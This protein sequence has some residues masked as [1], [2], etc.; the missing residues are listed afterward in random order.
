MN[1]IMRAELPNP[2]FA[3]ERWRTLNGQWDFLMDPE[4]CLQ[5]GGVDKLSWDRTIRVPFCYESELLLPAVCGIVAV[6]Q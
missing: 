5:V 4:D 6:L 1:S 2:S 3:R